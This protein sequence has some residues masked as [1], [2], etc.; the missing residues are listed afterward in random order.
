MTEY[1]HSLDSSRP[2]TA[3]INVLLNVYAK[4]GFG[5]YKEKG[6]YKAEPLTVNKAY[7]QKKTGSDFF[8]AMTQK[9]GKLMFFMSKGKKG[10]QACCE[11]AKM[12]DVLGLN[13]R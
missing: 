4:M 5:V 10:E 3:G 7:K 11:A 12:V 13:C 1:I 8:N 9:L 2:V 6:E